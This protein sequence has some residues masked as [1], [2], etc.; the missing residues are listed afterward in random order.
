LRLILIVDVE[1]LEPS[2]LRGA[3]KIISDIR[4]VIICEVLAGRVE[5]QLEEVMKDHHYTFYSYN[6][7]TWSQQTGI[8]GDHLGLYRDW[9][10]LPSE[11]DWPHETTDS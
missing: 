7:T 3:S 2:V 1:T 11:L 8:S 10:F 9:V 4:P 5:E 6:G